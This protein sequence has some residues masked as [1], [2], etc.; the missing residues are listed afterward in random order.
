MKKP[1]SRQKPEH[2]IRK[3]KGL[4]HLQYEYEK[5]QYKIGPTTTTKT[6]DTNKRSKI[7]RIGNM[8]K[9]AIQLATFPLPKPSTF[10]RTQLP[11]SKSATNR[12]STEYKPQIVTVSGSHTLLFLKSKK[13]QTATSLPCSKKEQNPT[14]KP[15]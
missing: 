7:Q 6:T 1:H 9:T 2:A 8:T 13:R 12:P 11:M 3:R 4:E 10:V 15:Q 14:S 5:H